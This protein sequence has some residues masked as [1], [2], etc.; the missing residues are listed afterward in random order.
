F[1]FE[2]FVIGCTLCCTA[3][4]TIQKSP[5]LRQS[6][7]VLCKWQMRTDLTL[8]L[9]TSAYSLIPNEYA[10]SQDSLMAI[11]ITYVAE[12]SYH[13]SGAM[14]DLFAVNRF[15]YIVF[16]KLQQAWRNATQ[17]ILVVC[18]VIIAFHTILMTI[19]DVNLYWVYDRETH[20]W[21]MTDSEWTEFYIQFFEVYWSTVEIAL[22]VSLDSVTFGYILLKKSE[23]NSSAKPVNRRTEARLVLQ[24]FCQCIPTTTVNIIFFYILPETKSENLKIVYSAIWI[25]TNII[26]AFIIIIFHFSF[27][28]ATKKKKTTNITRLNTAFTSEI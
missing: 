27:A 28:L 15:I 2:T 12:I 11:T 26:D 17:T 20:I 13:Y 25:V 7:G 1:P 6:F 14:H 23:I 24:S 9:V 10:P 18:A 16:P 19:L 22:I 4:W 21:H 5:T 3:L 8:L